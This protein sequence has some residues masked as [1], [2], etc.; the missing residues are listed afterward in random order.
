MRLKL[1]FLNILLLTSFAAFGATGELKFLNLEHNV[2]Y[3]GKKSL[4]AHFKVVIRGMKGQ[5][6]RLVIYI[7][8]PKGV[9]V[10]DQNNRY[11]TTDGH[12][13]SGE[14][15]TPGYDNTSWSDFKIYLPNSEIHPKKGKHTYYVR[16]ILWNGNKKLAEADCGSFSMTGDESPSQNSGAAQQKKSGASNGVVKTERVNLPY[17]YKIVQTWSNGNYLETLYFPCGMCSGTQRCSFCFGNGSILAAGYYYMPCSA[18]GQTGICNLCRKDNGYVINR[19]QL[20]DPNGKPLYLPSGDGYVGGGGSSG[21]SSSG[22]GDSR[23]G[24]YDCP[25]CYGSGTCQTCGGNGIA[26]SYY[27]GGSMSCP[28]CTSNR[29]RCSVCGGTGKKYGVK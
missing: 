4:C 2:N 13:S 15:L 9:G 22:S 1:V 28:N 24:Y 7:E 26:D 20:Y 17:G 6:A 12:V 18:C 16:A 27:T 11:H 3:N 21:G 5:K 10:V 23:Y 25:T 14:D 8:S 29:G 19:S